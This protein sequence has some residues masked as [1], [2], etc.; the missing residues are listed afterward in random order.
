MGEDPGNMIT[1]QRA[2]LLIG[3]ALRYTGMGISVLP[4]HSGLK[5]IDTGA[6]RASGAVDFR[7]VASWRTF[8]RRLAT[9]D[10]I[11]TWF[12]TGEGNLGIIS[13]IRDLLI[14]DFDHAESFEAWSRDYRHVTART[15]VQETARGFHVLFT[16]PQ[17][18]N[19]VLRTGPGFRVLAAPE[20]L[21]GSM[22]G[23]FEYV[24]AWPSIHPSGWRYRWLPGQAPWEVGILRI[25]SLEEIELVPDKRIPGAYFEFATKFFRDPALG[26]RL[27]KRWITYRFRRALGLEARS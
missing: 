9:E 20:R 6:L 23:P 25:E 21:A 15:S 12:S 10:E 24:V 14:L 11:C 22:K 3:A 19:T 27:M 7:G 5:T 17:A 18:W 8:S 13:G 2:A 26:L 16:W 4:I 1:R